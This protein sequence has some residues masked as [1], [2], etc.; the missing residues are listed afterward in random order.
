MPCAIAGFSGR[1]PYLPY[2]F[3]P[4]LIGDSSPGVS[5]GFCLGSSPRSARVQP[6]HV[7][8]LP[9]NP[10]REWLLRE[11]ELG[12]S[13]LFF[14]TVSPRATA[15]PSSRRH[16]IPLEARCAAQLSD[17][18]GSEKLNLLLLLA[19]QGLSGP[20]RIHLHGFFFVFFCVFCLSSV[21]QR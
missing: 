3:A 12:S 5:P 16:A 1:N 9:Q 2:L 17:S 18:L 10:P 15:A 19:P 8:L 4:R 21:C 20:T 7:R 14:V 11:R 6:L 13:A